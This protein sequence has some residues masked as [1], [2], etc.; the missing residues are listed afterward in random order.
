MSSKRG[1][2]RP[3]SRACR[4]RL[5]SQG[6]SR[7]SRSLVMAR[8]L[9][10]TSASRLLPM[11]RR[12]CFRV[13]SHTALGSPLAPSTL[14]FTRAVSRRK[15]P[16]SAEVLSSATQARTSA[17]LSASS[18]PFGALRLRRRGKV[19]SDEISAVP[20]GAPSDASPVPST[21]SARSIPL[22]QSLCT[23]SRMSAT[24]VQT[25]PFPLMP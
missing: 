6:R 8:T 20:S 25:D 9:A 24:P 16:L 14:S 3:S 7:G 10:N 4:G 5:C 1:Q 18:R 12:A 17:K 2:S 13:S 21:V 23:R 19:P 11:R 15:S 22:S